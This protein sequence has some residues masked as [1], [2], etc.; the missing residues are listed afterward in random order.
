M[1]SKMGA[2]PQPRLSNDNDLHNLHIHMTRLEKEY[3]SKQQEYKRKH[4]Y[5]GNKCAASLQGSMKTLFEVI[6]YVRKADRNL[7]DWH[8][9]SPLLKNALRTI[10]LDRRT[11]TVIEK[12]TQKLQDRVQRVEEKFDK[13]GLVFDGG[14]QEAKR[15]KSGFLEFSTGNVEKVSQEVLSARD[16][17]SQ[18]YERLDTIAKQQSAEHE[19]AQSKAEDLAKS[20]E[21]TKQS[22]D[23]A[24]WS[25][26]AW[27]TVSKASTYNQ[28]C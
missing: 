19:N 17:Y 4:A 8:Y 14:L 11:H 5:H 3:E 23:N 9:R 2:A 27:T 10:G 12:K 22:Q 7:V 28:L 21:V 15:M 6:V 1:Y 25:K 20:L 16:A 18:R 26:S 13:T 24:E